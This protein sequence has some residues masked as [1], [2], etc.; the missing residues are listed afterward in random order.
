M[1]GMITVTMDNSKF[2][3]VQGKFSR[4]SVEATTTAIQLGSVRQARS[5][6]ERIR[7]NASR[8]PGPNIVTGAY[9]ASWKMKVISLMPTEVIV[10]TD[11]PAAR[12]LEFG[13][14]DID[15]IGRRYHQPPFPHVR[16]ALQGFAQE[17]WELHRNELRKWMES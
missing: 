16:P 14:N 11:H 8:R 17:L 5:L 1:S 9:V 10:Y 7:T 3:R 2:Q 6:L 15:S 13:F 4:K 12:R